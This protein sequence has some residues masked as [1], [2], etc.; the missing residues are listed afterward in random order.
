MRHFSYTVN[1]LRLVLATQHVLAAHRN[2]TITAA[3]LARR[4]A[5]RDTVLARLA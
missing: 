3:D 2:A 1:R 4:I 5:R